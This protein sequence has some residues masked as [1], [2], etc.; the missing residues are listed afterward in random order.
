[1]TEIQVPE[2]A[3]FAKQPGMSGARRKY[4]WREMKV[5]DSFFI[6]T[7]HPKDHRT[8]CFRA[9]V[10]TSQRRYGIVLADIVRRDGVRVV[11]VG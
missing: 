5:G 7:G 11:R 4:P 1:M 3:R 2:G 8:V 10:R 9:L 6:A